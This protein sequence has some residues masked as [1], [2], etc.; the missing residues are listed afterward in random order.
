MRGDAIKLISPSG[1]L[2]RLSPFSLLASQWSNLISSCIIEKKTLG[3]IRPPCFFLVWSST[4]CLYW[5]SPRS[6]SR[7]PQIRLRQVGFHL[8]HLWTVFI[9]SIL[10]QA[11]QQCC[12]C[13][14]H[15]SPFLWLLD[16]AAYLSEGYRHL[17]TYTCAKCTVFVLC[18]SIHVSVS[19]YMV[20][21]Q[22]LFVCASLLD[23]W[24]LWKAC[25]IHNSGPDNFKF[26]N[27]LFVLVCICVYLCLAN[28][29]WIH[30]RCPVLPKTPT[31]LCINTLKGHKEKWRCLGAFV[32]S[33]RGV[34][35]KR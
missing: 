5:G 29:L 15:L 3:S 21:C 28:R 8:S 25:G 26:V 18:L 22:V 27:L 20:A 9:N 24:T 32:R 33:K 17:F 30:W 23:L 16:A 14:F 31:V 1:F 10:P 12:L 4:V 2:C 11:N 7:P 13:C 34:S 19:V 6:T 35:T